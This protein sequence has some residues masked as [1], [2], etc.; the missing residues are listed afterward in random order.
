MSPKKIIEM[1][2][3]I[4]LC[5]SV[6]M[7]VCVSWFRNG[8]KE[9]VNFYFHPPPYPPPLERIREICVFVCGNRAKASERNRERER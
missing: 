1:K 2:A 9:R 7:Y 6:C 8:R 5:A 4:V 3:L